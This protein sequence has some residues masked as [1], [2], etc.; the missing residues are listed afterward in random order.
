MP[1]ACDDIVRSVS[2]VNRNE[3]AESSR[4]LL[5]LLH[6]K[7]I[8][9]RQWGRPSGFASGSQAHRGYSVASDSC[10]DNRL[11]H[12]RA[13]CSNPKQRIKLVDRSLHNL[14]QF[15]VCDVGIF[16]LPRTR[17]TFSPSV[18]V[19]KRAIENARATSAVASFAIGISRVSL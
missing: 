4:P 15:A 11:I 1:R 12:I 18:P 19:F 2:T 3:A 14:L 10:S 9:W 7:R 8:W 5:E 6:F 17:G 16:V 13:V